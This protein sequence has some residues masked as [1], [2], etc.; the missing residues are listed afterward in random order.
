MN[1]LFQ[2]MND[3]H[4]FASDINIWSPRSNGRKTWCTYSIKISEAYVASD[5]Y[6]W[7]ARFRFIRI[8][9]RISVC[10]WICRENSTSFPFETSLL[11]YLWDRIFYFLH[12]C[13]RCH[14][15]VLFQLSDSLFPSSLYTKW[16]YSGSLICSSNIFFVMNFLLIWKNQMWIQ[17][18]LVTPQFSISWS[19]FLWSYSRDIYIQGLSGVQDLYHKQQRHSTGLMVNKPSAISPEAT[20]VFLPYIVLVLR[21][22]ITAWSCSADFYHILPIF[23]VKHRIK[24][25]NL[26]HFYGQ[27]PELF[28]LRCSIASTEPTSIFFLCHYEAKATIQIFVSACRIPSD[29]I[30]NLCFSLTKNSMQFVMNQYFISIW[31]KSDL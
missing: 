21:S 19:S 18:H 20:L 24:T 1:G 8:A 29:N 27:N 23:Q 7:S 13:I 14:L 30:L 17:I 3:I 22:Y 4:H 10:R 12:D 9:H 11:L 26:I 25:R 31:N 16:L 6:L 28:P 2:N 5:I 15:T